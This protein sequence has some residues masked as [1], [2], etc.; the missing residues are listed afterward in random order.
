MMTDTIADMLTRIRNAVAIQNETVEMPWSKIREGLAQVLKDEGF[1]EDY[2]LG[3]DGPKKTLKI[4]LKYGPLGQDIIREIKRVSKPGR[5]IYRSV[6]ELGHF[7]NGLGIWVV[8]TNKG[9]LSDRECRRQRVGGEVLC[10][11]F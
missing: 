6:D 8:S 4:Y 3:G 2:R 9:V 10:S 1:I 11:V 7:R 5:R